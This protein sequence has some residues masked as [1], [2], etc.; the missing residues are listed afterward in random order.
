MTRVQWKNIA[1][2]VKSQMTTHFMIKGAAKKWCDKTGVDVRFEFRDAVDKG[3]FKFDC[4]II[5]CIGFDRELYKT[6]AN[7][8]YSDLSDKVRY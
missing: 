4:V 8:Q 6:L 3:K 5:Q 7:D 2:H 1:E